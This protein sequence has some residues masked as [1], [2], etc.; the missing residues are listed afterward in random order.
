[1]SKTEPVSLTE[2]EMVELHLNPGCLICSERLPGLPVDVRYKDDRIVRFAGG[3]LTVY[4]G[5]YTPSQTIAREVIGKA[6]SKSMA[7]AWEKAGGPA[8]SRLL[9]NE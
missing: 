1:M 9:R 6:L 3:Y 2:E 5:Y 7:D 4:L 8:L